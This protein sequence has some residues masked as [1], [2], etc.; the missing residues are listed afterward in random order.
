MDKVSNTIK[1]HDSSRSAGPNSIP[2]KISTKKILIPLSDLFDKSINIGIFPNIS[3]LASVVSVL[4][5]EVRQLGNNSDLSLYFQI[6][7]K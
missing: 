2:M 6:L 1:T 7:V 5:C 3:K 4:K